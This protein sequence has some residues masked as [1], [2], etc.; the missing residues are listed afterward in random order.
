MHIS[1]LAHSSR[2]D[3]QPYLALGVGF[4]RAGHEVRLAAPELFRGFVA[5]YGL[6]FAPLAGDPRRP[7]R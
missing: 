4:Q 6:E 2:G 3:V 1:V 7:M 5:R